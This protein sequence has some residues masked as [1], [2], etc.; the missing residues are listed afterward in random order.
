MDWLAVGVTL[1]LAVGTTAILFVVG[2][3]LAYWLATSRARGVAIV[4][5]IVTLP[6]V[7]P[8]TVV[9]FY[10]L[11]LLKNILSSY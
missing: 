6:L 3:P 11:L 1:R 5:A 7:L 8:P 9:G 2:L 4:Q 10:L